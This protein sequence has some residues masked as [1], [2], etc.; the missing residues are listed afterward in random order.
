MRKRN[1]GLYTAMCLLYGLLMTGCAAEAD[2]TA[3]QVTEDTASV[4]SS[5]EEI[6]EA[7]IDY[8]AGVSDDEVMETA[9]TED[10]D[11]SVE[12]HNVAEISGTEYGDR[13]IACDTVSVTYNVDN[14][15]GFFEQKVSKNLEFCFDKETGAWDLV[16]ETLTGCEVDSS[17]IPG[18]SWKGEADELKK[19]FGSDIPEGDTGE[20]YIRFNKRA[21]LFAFNMNNENNTSSERFYTTSGTGGKATWVGAEGN[22]EVSFKVT[23]G[24]VTDAGDMI[25]NVVSD[26][27]TIGINFGT[28]V[29]TAT[30]MEYDMAVSGEI[31]EGRIYIEN[32]DRFE[33]TSSSI[34]GEEWKL[35]TGGK[36]ENQSPELSWDEVEGASLYAVMMID[37]DANNWLHWYVKVD[38]THLD[39]GEYNSKE[40]GYVGPYPPETHKYDVYVVALKGAPEKDGFLL[41]ATGEDVSS[42]LTTLNTA[43][44]GSTGNVISYGTVGANFTPGSDYYGDR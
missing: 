40:T 35:L 3:V 26:A 13:Y 5:T 22:V 39:E 31:E 25:M 30:E 38:K 7:A 9:F 19:L 11:A 41:D 29:V 23:D 34:E 43:A 12:A 1:I 27:G 44:D 8:S 24:S 10:V 37:K 32:L 36:E 15:T 6:T 14:P 21:G 33:V 17:V 18:S 16:A 2:S 28:D 4:E 20:V 42:K